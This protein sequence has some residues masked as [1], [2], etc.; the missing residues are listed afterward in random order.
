MT[1]S[2]FARGVGTLL[3]IRWILRGLGYQLMQFVCIPWFCLV[4]IL[5]VP[6]PFFERLLLVCSDILTS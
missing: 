3:Q 1:V 5:E 2:S 6:F 4:L